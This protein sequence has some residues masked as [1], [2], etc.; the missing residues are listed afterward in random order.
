AGLTEI[1][2]P[3]VADALNKTGEALRARLNAVGAAAGAPLCFTG[4][5]SMLTVQFRTPAPD[6]PFVPTAGEEQ[7]R[8]LF[9][10]DMLE[11]GIYLARRGMV[12]LSLPVADADLDRFVDAVTRFAESRAEQLRAGGVT[13]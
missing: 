3:A 10:F 4:V 13:G 7:L 12:A 5:G 1:Y 11:A 8:E 6:R 9:F 2:P